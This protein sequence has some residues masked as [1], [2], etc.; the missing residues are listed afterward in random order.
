[1]R[2][3]YISYFQ[4]KG[5]EKGGVEIWGFVVSGSV[6]VCMYV[7]LFPDISYIM[8]IIETIGLLCILSSFMLGQGSTHLNILIGGEFNYLFS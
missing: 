6:H 3:V 7:C 8:Y 5:R 1:M 4:R 2:V